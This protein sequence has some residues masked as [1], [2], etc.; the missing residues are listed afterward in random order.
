MGEEVKVSEAATRTRRRW[1]RATWF[2]VATFLAWSPVTTVNRL[3]PAGS[4]TRGVVLTLIPL[5][6][7]LAVLRLPSGGRRKPLDLLAGLLALLVVW[8]AISVERTAGTS[9]LLHVIPAAA[10]LVLAGAARGQVTEMS[11]TDIRY[12]VTGVLPGLCFLLILG[13]IVQY[14]HLV[15]VQSTS[16]SSLHLSFS[17]HGYRLQGLASGSDPLGFLAA[18][19][20]LIAF[21][22]QPEKLSWFTRAVGLLTLFATDSRTSIIVL[23]VGL[24]MLWVFGPERSMA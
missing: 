15:P 16:A 8:Q 19:V 11:L 23:A 2:G 17:V 22:A 21:V 24:F 6:G 13:W 3:L 9:T 18:L 12:A 10:L 14:A 7:V 1:S 5:I 4:T 20:T